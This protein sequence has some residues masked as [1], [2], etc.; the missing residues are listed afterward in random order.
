MM[1][2]S[3]GMG[4]FV[5]T[6]LATAAYLPI[7][8]RLQFIDA[9][10]HRSAHV[11][12]TP[13]SGGLAIVFAVALSFLTAHVLDWGFRERATQLVLCML[14][15]LCGLGAWDDRRALSVYLRLLAFFA[16]SIVVV[17][18]SVNVVSYAPWVGPLLILALAWLLNL[19]NFMDGIDGL[20]ALQAVVV[21]GGMLVVGLA[22]G[23]NSDFLLLSTI[24]LGAFA[25]FLVFNWP[26]A[27]LFMGDSGSLSAGLLLGWL[28]LW[29]WQDALMSPIVWLLLMSPFL[30]D[31][32][33]T[34]AS[35]ALQ[36]ERLTEA[37]SGHCYQRLARHWGSHRRVDIAMLVLQGV[38]LLP[39][40][41][42]SVFSTIPEWTLLVL[43]LFPQLFLIAK[44]RRLT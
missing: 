27:K 18:S 20:A 37:H 21:A 12:K 19:Y 33:V 3:L 25:G 36:G 26:P 41:L 40:S 16:V 32:G 31:T 5:L 8:R 38:W 39:L 29:A 2:L 34:L 30:L 44:L 4:A 17:V 13:S 42:M 23:A 10:N 15:L 6:L 1:L 7:A 9:P 35:R 43:G 14:L 28:G 22:N 24:V 11:A